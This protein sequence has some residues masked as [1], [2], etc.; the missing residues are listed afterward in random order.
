VEFQH[1]KDG[2][3]EAL[4]G[5]LAELNREDRLHINWNWARL[6]W[7][8]GHPDFDLASMESIGLWWE[9]GRIVAAAIYD[10]Y[11]G[12]AFCG[13]LPG[14]ETLYPAVLDYAD[15][16][17]RD[18]NGLGV[19]ACDDSPGEIAA[20][21]AAGFAPSQ[22]TETLMRIGLD[23]LFAP[24]LPAGLSLA[25]IGPEADPVALEWLFWQ[26]FD[27]GTDR[28][29][30]EAAERSSFRPRPHFDRRL[31]LAAVT[32]AGEPVSYCCLWYRPG[33][34]YAYVEPVCTIPAWRGK[35]AARA[36][37]YEAMNRARSFGAREAWVISDQAFYERLGFEKTLRY[38]FYW[39]P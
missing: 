7:M 4:C 1:Y 24:K 21:K 3:Y 19:A 31:S 12:E 30:F 5:F 36:L 20:L 27:H 37:L 23:R 2:D 14:Y 9:T 32:P 39:K 15:R 11:F 38:T 35:G 18:E 10:M 26:G 6:E 8:Y 13:V 33:T 28:A 34:E 25:E 22:Q 17:L 29:V 16:E